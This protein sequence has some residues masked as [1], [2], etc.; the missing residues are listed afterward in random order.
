MDSYGDDMMM[1]IIIIIIITDFTPIFCFYG[2]KRESYD[3]LHI[4]SYC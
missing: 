4:T 1:M 3:T 2:K